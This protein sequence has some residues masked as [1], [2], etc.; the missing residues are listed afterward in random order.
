MS[1]KYHNQGFQSDRNE[2]MIQVLAQKNSKGEWSAKGAF[3]FAF[4]DDGS[5]AFV[6]PPGL[7]D[8]D[9]EE[10]CQRFMVLM[11]EYAKKANYKMK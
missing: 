2:K 3:L 11:T 6:V 7:S 4:Y 9:A 1:F 5:P 10:F 8:R